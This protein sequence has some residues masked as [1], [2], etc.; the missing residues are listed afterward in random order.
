MIRIEETDLTGENG[1]VDKSKTVELF[2]VIDGYLIKGKCEAIKE[3][4][5]VD[6][7]VEYVGYVEPMKEV[8]GLHSDIEQLKSNIQY[9][10]EHGGRVEND[11]VS[12]IIIS[13]DKSY[14]SKEIKMS[15][16][17]F[18]NMYSKVSNLIQ[19]NELTSLEAIEEYY[20]G[21]DPVS[22]EGKVLNTYLTLCSRHCFTFVLRKYDVILCDKRNRVKRWFFY[23]WNDIALRTKYKLCNEFQI[24][25]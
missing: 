19:T 24:L 22:E 12:F 15:T 10:N 1:I 18:E 3:R 7:V 20:K 4:L 17:S 11:V 21:L 13:K 25:Y 9:I 23:D 14:E 2:K 16:E 6:D 8:T 5:E